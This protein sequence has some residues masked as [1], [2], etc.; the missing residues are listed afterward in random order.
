MLLKRRRRGGRWRA[1]TTSTTSLA[2]T[3][4]RSAPAYA[5][6]ACRPRHPCSATGGAAAFAVEK[7]STADWENVLL[8]AAVRRDSSNITG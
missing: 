4:A 3:A 6:V 1:M 8:H 2:V 7:S 5:A